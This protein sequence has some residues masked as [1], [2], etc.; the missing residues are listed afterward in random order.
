MNGQ[1]ITP[2]V[3][4]IFQL[5]NRTSIQRQIITDNRNENIWIELIG[6][7]KCLE[8]IFNR[9]AVIQETE[10]KS[11]QSIIFNMEEAYYSAMVPYNATSDYNSTNMTM[12]EYLEAMRGPKQ[13]P[14]NIAVPF[15]VFNLLI[16][17][18]GIVGNISVCVVI[19]RH[20]SMH[21]ATNYYLFSLAIS[22]LTLLI[23]G[24]WLSHY[25]KILT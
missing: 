7:W 24:K 23:F 21:T 1:F 2:F 6:R 14:L 13:L 19:V 4:L 12:E 9:C 16:F 25:F 18:T 20:S 5:D 15:T 10:C 3:T 8:I 17:V 11:V 22:D